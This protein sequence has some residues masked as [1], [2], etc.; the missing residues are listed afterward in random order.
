MY[1]AFPD[2]STVKNLL[3][4][5]GDTGLISE[6]GRSH[7]LLSMCYTISEPV[8][9]SLGATGAEAH[10]LWSPQATT[11]EKPVRC[12]KDPMSCN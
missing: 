4:N 3:A 12:H 7:M 9:K 5:A 1:M 10:V 11:R 6:L 8:L 2:G